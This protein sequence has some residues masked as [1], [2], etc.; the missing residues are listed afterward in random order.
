MFL[1]SGNN[2][3]YYAG[4]FS[5]SNYTTLYAIDN[6]AQVLYA[7]NTASGVQSAIG[8]SAPAAGQTWTGMGMDVDP[9]TNLL[10]LAAYNNTNA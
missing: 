10:Y 4:D 5:G 8:P 6:V 7:I 9:T 1:A 2:R 3:E